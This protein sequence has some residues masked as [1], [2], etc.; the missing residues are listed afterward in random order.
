MHT[1]VSHAL[2]TA[3]T[4]TRAR[5]Q[6]HTDAHAGRGAKTAGSTTQA[7]CSPHTRETT[8][9]AM[10]LHARQHSMASG[11]CAFQQ[12]TLP[13]ASQACGRAPAGPSQPARHQGGMLQAGAAA[14]GAASVVRTASKQA[15]KQHMTGV[16]SRP[17]NTAANHAACRHGQKQW[18][19]KESYGNRECMHQR[20]SRNVHAESHSYDWC[21]LE[22]HPHSARQDRPRHCWCVVGGRSTTGWQTSTAPSITLVQ[23]HTRGPEDS[24]H[25]HTP[26]GSDGCGVHSARCGARTRNTARCVIL[27][28]CPRGARARARRRPLLAAQPTGR[29]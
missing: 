26:V 2:A 22:L 16:R 1:H 25:T 14:A 15:S 18:Q 4:H 24:T 28:Y 3:Q 21:I 7:S 9:R 10:C 23:W 17:P 5:T 12:H 19:H 13:L 6:T 27:A 8:K 11:W 29:M 20:Q